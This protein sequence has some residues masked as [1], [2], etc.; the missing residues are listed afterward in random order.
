MKKRGGSPPKQFLWLL[1]QAG[2]GRVARTAGQAGDKLS[3]GGSSTPANE[4]CVGDPRQSS[5]CDGVAGTP[6]HWTVGK[7]QQR[8]RAAPHE[9]G[10]DTTTT[11]R[12]EASRQ[13][14]CQM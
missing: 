12:L 8:H 10:A 4:D 1:L 3:L 5:L 6:P 14:P 9:V 7:E 13:V 11:W 2:I